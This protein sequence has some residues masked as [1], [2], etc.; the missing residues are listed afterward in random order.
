MLR[1]Q[2]AEAIIAA[3]A[4]IVEG[5]VGMVEMALPSSSRRRSSSSTRS[6]E[7]KEPEEGGPSLLVVL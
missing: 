7:K 5:A 1:R 2:Q 3:R 4:R 6:A